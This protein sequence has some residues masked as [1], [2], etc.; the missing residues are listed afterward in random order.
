M[1]CSAAMPMTHLPS[2]PLPY[3]DD[4]LQRRH[5]HDAREDDDGERLEA[6]LACE[7][8]RGG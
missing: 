4:E 5:A 3:L 8:K 7:E 2:P 6:R 1:S